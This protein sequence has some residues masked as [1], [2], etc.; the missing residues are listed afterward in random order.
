[1]GKALKDGT[2]LKVLALLLFLMPVQA[3]GK[4][5]RPSAC[6][7]ANETV[8]TN[9]DA[10]LKAAQYSLYYFNSRRGCDRWFTRSK[11]LEKDLVTLE[12][13]KN[14]LKFIIK[15]IKEDKKKGRK[16]R[17]L[18]PQFLKK[19]FS[20]IRW[21]SDTRSALKNKLHLPKWHDQG[22]LLNGKIKLTSYAIFRRKGNYYKTK[23]YSCPIY[24]IV[25][26]EFEKKL[27]FKYTRQQ[28]LAGALEKPHFKKHV[29]PLV[30]LSKKDLEEAMM[31]GSV[32]VIMPNGKRRFFNVF[33]SNGFAYD[34]KLKHRSLQKKYWFFNEINK[35][36]R[37][38]ER[39]ILSFLNFGGVVFAGDYRNI[40]YGKIIALQ[41]RNLRTRKKEFRLG[42]LADRGSAFSNNLYQLDL[43]SGV[44]NSYRSFKKFIDQ[45]PPSLTAYIL[46]KR[47]T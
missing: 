32:V 28:I 2:F 47:K 44:F 37:I 18:D 42:V 39:R 23:H 10:L 9:P 16:Q 4:F 36:T 5:F 7:L 12:Q 3:Y 19:H 20:F 13:T 34:K 21:H 40:G 31:Q 14:T 15:T 11:L 45:F 22:K 25:S 38:E 30:W 43:F 35:K 1:M 29:K 41:Y 8:I 26:K 24:G 46:K 6:P 17:I 33:K 27:R